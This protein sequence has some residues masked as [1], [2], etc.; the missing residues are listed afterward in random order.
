MS[1]MKVACQAASLA[2]A[3]L[4]VGENLLSIAISTIGVYLDKAGLML[5]TNA[6][7]NVTYNFLFGAF[8][9]S[10]ALNSKLLPH[11]RS[12]ILNLTLVSLKSQQ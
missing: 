4:T 7:A 11:T 8:L 3:S 2:L 9:C 1:S 6:T 5:G 10:L 12:A